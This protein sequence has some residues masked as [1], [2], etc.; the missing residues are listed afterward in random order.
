M[1]INVN[2]VIIYQNN[3]ALMSLSLSSPVTY[4]QLLS[5]EYMWAI[6]NQNKSYIYN[7]LLR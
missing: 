4:V 3:M 2:T 1:Y 6:T 5:V 7:S